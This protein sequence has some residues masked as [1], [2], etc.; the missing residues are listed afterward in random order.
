M[1]NPLFTLKNLTKTFCCGDRNIQILSGIDVELQSGT[2]TTIVGESG[3]GKSTLLNMIGGLESITSGEILFRGES[4]GSYSDKE[5]TT[6]R[7]ENLGFI[8]QNPILLSDFTLLENCYLPAY[9]AGGTK[10]ELLEQSK[11]LLKQVGLSH[12]LDH[13]PGTLSGGE[14]QRLSIARA[15]LQE[16]SIILADEPTGSL[17]EEISETIQQIFI[18]LV[19][20]YK[21]TL[22]LV[23]HNPK[24]AQL[25]DQRIRLTRGKVELY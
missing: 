13:Y 24:L 18:D 17:D 11:H 4:I 6:Y 12:R 14:Q 1:S 16:P 5:L 10:R 25:G 20:Q 15:M 8:F 23:T 2:I 21:V 7:R 22:L 3:S 9:L 19:R